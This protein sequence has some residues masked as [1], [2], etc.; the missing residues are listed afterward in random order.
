MSVQDLY[1]VARRQVINLKKLEGDDWFVAQ[2]ELK[3]TLRDI[4]NRDFLVLPKQ[5]LINFLSWCSSHR[6]VEPFQVLLSINMQND[7]RL[8][9]S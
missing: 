2:E 7:I 8:G 4:Y 3:K 9:M 5:E 6:P 1:L